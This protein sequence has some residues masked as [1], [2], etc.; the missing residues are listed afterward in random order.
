MTVF[1]FYHF[2]WVAQIFV[3]FYFV[4]KLDPYSQIDQIKLSIN[5]N[6]RI[7]DKRDSPKKNLPENERK[8]KG[9]QLIGSHEIVR[10]NRS[11]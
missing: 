8:K 10:M 5:G 7:D 11:E 1:L 3:T 2:E 9:Q 6:M 4:Q